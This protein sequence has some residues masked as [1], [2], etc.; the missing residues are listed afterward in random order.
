[1]RILAL[2]ASTE[3][4]AAAIGDG[5]AWL[6]R[7]DLAGQRHSELLL[8]MV[9]ALLTEARLEL[10]DL[11]GIAFG[12]GP[13]S[14]TGLRI[15]CGVAQGLALGANLPMIG[16]A[17]LEAMAETARRR[18]AS[19]RV[20]AALDARMHEVYFAA[21]E[22][23]GARWCARVAPSVVAPV[24]AFLP[25]GEGWSGAGNG[26]AA[27][28]A[29]RER[30]GGVLVSCDESVLPTAVAVGALALPRFAAGE[31]IPARDAA[32]LYV[33]HRVA[34]AAGYSAAVGAADGIIVAYGVLLIAPG[35]VQLLNLTVAPETR[36]LGI[37]R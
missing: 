7:A 35:E 6:E 26:F 12:A 9:R 13:G 8:P 11:D 2:D 4:C 3:V 34:L 5:T 33:R 29:L 16:V 10:A 1:M 27:Y 25:G 30:F 14:F 31:G 19:T 22:H 28:P 37:G 23:D 20:I 17:T 32:P 18:N 15:A 36:R 24:S 21:Y